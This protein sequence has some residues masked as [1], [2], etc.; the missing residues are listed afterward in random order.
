[1]EHHTYQILDKDRNPSDRDK[2]LEEACSVP[3][4][5]FD[6]TSLQIS[7]SPTPNTPMTLSNPT[8]LPELPTPS[9]KPNNPNTS[10]LYSYNNNTTIIDSYKKRSKQPPTSTL[11]T[12]TPVVT[13]N[14]ASHIGDAERAQL[15]NAP[16]GSVNLFEDIELQSKSQNRNFDAPNSSN[17]N[18]TT[19]FQEN[20]EHPSNFTTS[21]PSSSPLSFGTNPSKKSAHTQ[22]LLNNQPQQTLQNSL[23]Q[24]TSINPIHVLSNNSMNFQQNFL[25]TFSDI[26]QS[27]TEQ[28]QSSTVLTDLTTSQL[29]NQ[30]EVINFTP[31]TNSATNA[32]QPTNSSHSTSTSHTN[33]PPAQ[34]Q[35]PQ[36]TATPVE[37]QK[38]LVQHHN[39]ITELTKQNVILQNKY[40]SLKYK[41][42]N[43]PPTTTP[44]TPNSH[45]AFKS[46]LQELQ[47]QMDTQFTALTTI[48]TKIFNHKNIASN[49]TKPF[50]KH[51]DLTQQFQN[52][53]LHSS[54][55]TTALH[56][57]AFESST[58]LHAI[59]LE[60]LYQHEAD[61][62]DSIQN[63]STLINTH[64]NRLTNGASSPFPDSLF[65]SIEEHLSLYIQ[66]KSFTYQSTLVKYKKDQTQ[67]RTEFLEQQETLQNKPVAQVITEAVRQQVTAQLN[68]YNYT[69]KD[70]NPNTP[71]GRSNSLQQRYKTNRNKS[72]SPS[73]NRNTAKPHQSQ[74]T[75]MKPK[76][77][78]PP[79]IHT[80]PLKLTTKSTTH[81]PKSTDET[82]PQTS[83][84]FEPTYKLAFHTL[85]N[86]KDPNNHHTHNFPNLTKHS[87]EDCTNKHNHHH[88]LTLPTNNGLLKQKIQLSCKHHPHIQTHKNYP[89]LSNNNKQ[90]FNKFAPLTN[91]K[92]TK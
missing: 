17:T 57:L 35:V 43:P 64:V 42:N 23:S 3:N 41:F 22:V 59:F 54:S 18:L 47:K 28:S 83:P 67:K 81:V 36:T 53:T 16:S 29:T 55:N 14:L 7:P 50:S 60:D 10:S 82:H 1:M 44:K 87:F 45:P 71:R 52:T 39:A 34:P 11:T 31:P 90:T 8:A 56:K 70:H 84:V 2:S 88:H 62:K 25:T 75:T 40:R 30:T 37:Y 6:T 80:H 89:P 91:R 26:S 9:T 46:I 77:N 63:V 78:P 74:L 33:S 32:T 61:L 38:L 19:K 20:K 73:P 92:T 48:S 51:F 65:K 58:K 4:I 86:C 21:P 15:F 24:I 27:A 49:T 76:H 68:K 72:T 13:K 79:T 66:N 5:P 85:Q 12:T 69:T